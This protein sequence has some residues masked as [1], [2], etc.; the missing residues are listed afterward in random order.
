MAESIVAFVHSTCLEPQVL[1]NGDT[2]DLKITYQGGAT[3]TYSGVSLEDAK[4]LVNAPSK[5]RYVNQVIKGAY[6]YT[7]G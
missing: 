3:Y 6:G 5:G 1:Y 4:G 7:K 2:Q